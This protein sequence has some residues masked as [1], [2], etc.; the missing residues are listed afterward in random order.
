VGRTYWKLVIEP[1]EITKVLAAKYDLPAR[2]ILKED[3]VEVIQLPRR[4]MQKDVYEV[5]NTS[6]IKL[7]NNLA[8]LINIPKGNQLS[9]AAIGSY[10]EALKIKAPKKGSDV[11]QNAR[12]AADPQEIVQV[13]VARYDLRSCTT[14]K[15]DLVEV[16]KLPRRYVQQDA[17]E[18]RNPSDI[19]LINDLVAV[20]RIS[21]GNQI[22]MSA[23]RR[24]GE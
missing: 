22:P 23:I 16:I 18:I 5:K 10:S 14:L 11:A 9:L 15:E 2:T 4:Y 7:I 8:A 13:L 24:P 3:L 1:R 17:Y 19:K 6:D 20:I 21:K 12:P